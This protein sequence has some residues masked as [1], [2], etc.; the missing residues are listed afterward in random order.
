[1]TH[2]GNITGSDPPV[3]EEHQKRCN[4][5]YCA[6]RVSSVQSRQVKEVSRDNVPPPAALPASKMKRYTWSETVDLPYAF[7]TPF[8]YRPADIRTFN[9]AVFKIE[10]YKL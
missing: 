10:L 9:N 7:V 8:L 4:H 2:N 6:L 5:Y 1:M 3:R